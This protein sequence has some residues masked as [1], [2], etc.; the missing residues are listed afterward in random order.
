[1]RAS[2]GPPHGDK[3]SAEREARLRQLGNALP[4]VA[5]CA[6]IETSSSLAA[7]GFEI[8]P[9]QSAEHEN[10]NFRMWRHAATRVPSLTRCFVNER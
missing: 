8:A 9:S 4:V 10:R 5:A 3:P 2:I 1:M 7:A 6:P